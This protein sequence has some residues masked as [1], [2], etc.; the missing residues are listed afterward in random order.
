MVSLEDAGPAA[1]AAV[2][3]GE[4]VV[5]PDAAGVGASTAYDTVVA[6]SAVTVSEACGRVVAGRPGGGVGGEPT[7][8]DDRP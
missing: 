2:G 4:D 5:A 3:A 6:V 7:T 1:A 8:A